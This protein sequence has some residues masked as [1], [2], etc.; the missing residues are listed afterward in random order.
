MKDKMYDFF[1]ETFK[2]IGKEQEFNSR[3]EKGNI[4]RIEI[5]DSNRFLFLNYATSHS[6]IYQL[7]NK[8]YQIYIFKDGFYYKDGNL[9]YKNGKIKTLIIKGSIGPT[10]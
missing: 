1:E 3:V 7:G 8:N 9:I 2:K 10:K 6:S 4:V 5:T